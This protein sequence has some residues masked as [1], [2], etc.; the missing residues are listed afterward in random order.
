M[1]KL[2][3]IMFMQDFAGWSSK[4]KSFFEP[5]SDAQKINNDV[6][7]QITRENL[8]LMSDNMA[9]C[10]KAAQLTNKMNR[11]EEFMKSQL[12]LLSGQGERCLEYWKNLMNIYEDGFKDYRQWV[13]GKM[14]SAFEQEAKARKGESSEYR[15]E[16]RETRSN[17][18]SN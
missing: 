2:E 1:H 10:M 18:R 8:S 9:A 6:L 3:N 16:T 11:P 12:A 15:S 13:E 5:Y 14:S 7:E 17:H 4:N